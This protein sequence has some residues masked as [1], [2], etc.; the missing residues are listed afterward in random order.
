MF[1]N[2]KKSI[3]LNPKVY[4]TITILMIVHL[5]TILIHLYNIGTSHL[6]NIYCVNISISYLGMIICTILFLNVSQDT[7]RNPHSI[8][9]F[10]LNLILCYAILA[11]DFYC[12]SYP[13]QTN[14]ACKYFLDSNVY[15]LEYIQLHVYVLYFQSKIPEKTSYRKIINIISNLIL[16]LVIVLLSTNPITKIFF[17]YLDGNYTR[18]NTFYISFIYNYTII[19]LNFFIVVFT[20][21]IS[22]KKKISFSFITVL[23]I[24]PTI[25]HI[26]KYG[27]IFTDLGIFLALVIIYA[28]VQIE[29]RLEFMQSKIQLA[30]AQS[31]VMLSQIQPHFLYNSLATISALCDFDPLLAQ[32]ATDRFAAYLRMNIYSIKCKENIPFEKELDHIQT[33]L[34]LEQLRFE[35]RLRV[36][37]KIKFTKFSVPPLSIQPLVENA[38]KHGLCK[39]PEGGIITL[40]TQK[41]KEFCEIIIKDN[42]VGFNEELLFTD[43]NIHIG[44]KSS[45]ERI[46]SILHGT[47][48]IDSKIGIGTSIL[49]RFPL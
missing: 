5:L 23:L 24:T 31:E 35:N 38:V 49:I 4:Y 10:Q 16:L 29:E 48:K 36:D 21:K 18:T 17:T 37:Y 40:I 12:W 14:I 34:W 25:P 22:L 47:M 46:E 26:I 43:E 1:S 33:Y 19:I 39:K 20:D 44:L 45:K 11:N 13:P 42:G 32:N 30:N 27:L 7:V 28:N 2:N 9:L 41:R 8:S 3:L 6:I 15:F